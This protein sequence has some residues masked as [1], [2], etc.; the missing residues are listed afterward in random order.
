MFAVFRLLFL[1]LSG[2]AALAANARA[3]AGADSAVSAA[4]VA[5]HGG[6]WAQA[7]ARGMCGGAG[8]SQPTANDCE[9]YNPQTGCWE[10]SRRRL[11]KGEM[12]W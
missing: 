5:A 6:D 8:G 9:I 11:Q 12:P 1:A 2:I 10:P 7:Y 4:L 3:D